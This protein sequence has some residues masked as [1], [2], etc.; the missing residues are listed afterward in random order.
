MLLNQDGDQPSA[1]Y[2]VAKITAVEE[3]PNGKI[4]IEF[5]FPEKFK[6]RQDTKIKQLLQIL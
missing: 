2:F 3:Q 4:A 5:H 6:Q 1:S